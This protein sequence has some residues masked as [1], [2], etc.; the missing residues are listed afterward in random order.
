MIQTTPL[1]KLGCTFLITSVLALAACTGTKKSEDTL[2]AANNADLQKADAHI[3][4]GDVLAALAIYDQLTSK[5]EGDA[6]IEL[7]LTAI[8][9]LLNHQFTDLAAARLAQMDESN[10]STEPSNQFLTRKRILEA[11]MALN[12][13]DAHAALRLVPKA[14]Q[15]TPLALEA[16]ILEVHAQIFE[17]QDRISDAIRTRIGLEPLLPNLKAIERNHNRIW[18]ALAQPSLLELAGMRQQPFGQVYQGWIALAETVRG[19]RLEQSSLASAVHQW[20][21]HYPAHPGADQ[22]ASALLDSILEDRSYPHQIALLLPLS[23]RYQQVATAVR[24]GFF[25]AYYDSQS[26]ERRPDIRVYSVDDTPESFWQNYSKA[27]EEGARLVIGPLDK[28]SVNALASYEEL[29]VPVLSLNYADTQ[30]TTSPENLYQFGLLP[31]DEAEQAAEFVLSSGLRRAVALAPQNAW[32]ERILEAFK[33]R[34]QSLGGRL[35]DHALY[36][37]EKN[38]FSAPIRRVMG[39]QNSQSRQAILTA[40]IRAKANFEPRRREDIDLIFLAALPKNAR[41][42]RPQFKFHHSGDI[43][44]YSTSHVHSGVSEPRL[45]KDMDGMIYAD[46]PLVLG[47]STKMQQTRAQL[48]QLWPTSAQR[49]VRPL[50][51][52][53]GRV[54]SDSSLASTKGK[55]GRSL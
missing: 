11:Q 54:S 43:P 32:G 41:L 45:D 8:E 16:K 30:L 5:A 18:L 49:L 36:I 46:I 52:R 24:D 20:L 17:L 23:G 25:A 42:I 38:D 50:R 2:P 37:G 35:A 14:T 33:N 6:R 48:E 44:M 4:D 3:A 19:A 21:R 15:E 40:T 39:L 53:H 27:V 29:S 1:R 9:V 55:P 51:L 34:Y 31:E 22:F 7:Q 47:A 12:N 28:V 13:Q 26:D 10:L